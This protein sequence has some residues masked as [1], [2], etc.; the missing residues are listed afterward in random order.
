[1]TNQAARS[2]RRTKPAAR[3]RDALILDALEGLLAQ[4]PLSDLGVEEIA[5]EAGITR[6]RFY[7]YYESKYDAYQALLERVLDQTLEAYKEP[8][9]WLERPSDVRPREAFETTSEMAIDIWWK[10]RFVLREA[11]DMWKAPADVRQM[12]VAMIGTI[13]TLFAQAIERDRQAGVA[14]PGPP[15]KEL[16][17]GLVWQA[18]RSIFLAILET[19]PRKVAERLDVLRTTALDMAM[20]AIYLADDPDP[21]SD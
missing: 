8:T 2:R 5:Q 21:A 15:A 11:A 6:T 10:H 16:A 13:A 7:H 3:P 17:E 12:W 14:P 9:G 4:T 20:R 18:E 1:M 19:D